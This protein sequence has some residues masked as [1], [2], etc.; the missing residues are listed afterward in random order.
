MQLQSNHWAVLAL[1]VAAATTYSSSAA[2]QT[3]QQSLVNALTLGY[4]CHVRFIK[5]PGNPPKVQSVHDGDAYTVYY[6]SAN[7]GWYSA[8]PN[9][10]SE[11]PYSDINGLMGY[12]HGPGVAPPSENTV[13]IIND[14]FV[15]GP[16][17][18]LWDASPGTRASGQLYCDSGPSTATSPPASR[19]IDQIKAVQQKLK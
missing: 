19:P 3:T 7:G 15:I 5:Q 1:M 10:N 18:W 8:G 16:T 9:A 17:G 14:L 4:D 2:S 11:H 12:K 6:N 13:W